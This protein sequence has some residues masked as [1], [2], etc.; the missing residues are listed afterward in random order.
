MIRLLASFAIAAATLA[1]IAA[2]AH[3]GTPG[4]I[5]TYAGTGAAAMAGD[6]GAASAAALNQPEDVAWLADGS[7]LVADTRNHRVRRI[8]PSGL[9]A[10]VAGTGVPGFSG[11][12]GAAANAQL[13]WPCGVEPTGDGGFL[14]ADLG[15]RRV[16][17]V[18]AEGTIATVAGTGAAGSSGNGGPATSASLD[19]PA[20]VATTPGGGFLIADAGSDRVR[21]VSPGGTISTVAGGGSSGGDDDDDDDDD[22]GPG[23]SGDGGPA[24]SAQLHSPAGVVAAP[25]G[26]F[27]V[28]ESQGHRVRLVSPAGTI[29]TVAGTGTAGFSGDG[30][31]ATSAR[32]SQPA[33]ISATPDGGFLIADS[34]NGRVRKI[35]AH[36]TIATV[37]GGQTGFA[38]DGGPAALASLNLPHAAVTGPG[39]AMLIADAGNNRLRL[40]EGAPLTAVT[41]PSAESGGSSSGGSG[42]SSSVGG[43]AAAARSRLVLKVPRTIR[44]GANGIFRI[45]IGC[46]ATATEPC[47][48]AIRLQLRV[49]PRRGALRAAAARAGMVDAAAAGRGAVRA[50]AAR[51]RARRRLIARARYSVAPGRTKAVKLRLSRSARRLLR[52]R[53]TLPVR[54]VATRRGGPNIGDDSDSVALKLKSKRKRGRSG[55]RG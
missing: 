17:K 18:S 34:L 49:R 25:G 5:S 14:I 28:S 1:S 24:T 3:A 4:D 27:L 31:A 20:A 29:T 40:V 54:A 8:W 39:G 38:G 23:G 7:V 19:E 43:N 22:G 51:P 53:G 26:G 32:L 42:V 47:R 16:R 37:A 50:A 21:A 52:K 55:G 6:G 41:T 48:G 45:R 10:T 30:G 15:N 35:T 9:I 11:D 33:E 2:P 12:G 36:G 46:P 13:N 44:V